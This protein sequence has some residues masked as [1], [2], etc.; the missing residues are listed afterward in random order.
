MKVFINIKSP[1]YT[2]ENLVLRH[3]VHHFPPDSRGIVCGVAEFNDAL[4]LDTRAK[5]WKYKYFDIVYI[6]IIVR[7]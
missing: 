2:R 7:K 4:C 1:P 3:S 6:S 5:K